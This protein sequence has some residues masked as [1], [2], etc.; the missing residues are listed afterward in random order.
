M[1]VWKFWDQNGQYG[2]KHQYG[3]KRPVVIYC[4]LCGPKRSSVIVRFV[5]AAL[6]LVQ[7]DKVEKVIISSPTAGMPSVL[8]FLTDS[9]V[10]TAAKTEDVEHKTAKKQDKERAL[11]MKNS[12]LEGA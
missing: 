7:Q 12:D 6:R 10:D 9:K 5:E 3:P 8:T 4:C 2:P 11:T 1:G